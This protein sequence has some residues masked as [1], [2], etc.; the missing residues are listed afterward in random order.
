[1]DN[2]MVREPIVLPMGLSTQDRGNKDC[3]MVLGEFLVSGYFH[4]T[5][6]GNDGYTSH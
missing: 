1:M 4:S 2:M 5:Q 6:S 3:I